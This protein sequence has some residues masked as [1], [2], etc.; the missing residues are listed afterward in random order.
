MKY[1]LGFIGAGNMAEALARGALR[2]GVVEAPQMLAA[3]PSPE[4]REVFD[5]LG[6]A[7]AADPAAVVAGCDHV[8]L[9]VKPQVFAA[10]SPVLAALDRKQQ[11]VIS[12]MAGVRSS[13]IEAAAG[14]PLRILRVMPN[15]P[16]LVGRGMSGMAECSSAEGSRGD[17]KLCVDLLRSC[18]EVAKVTE[19]DMDAVTAVSGSGPAYVFLLAE[20]MMDAAAEMGLLGAHELFVQQTICGAAEMLMQSEESA[21]ELRRKVTSPGGTTQAAIESFD[22]AGFRTMVRDAMR[23][24]CRRSAELGA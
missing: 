4:R 23:A 7:T 20:A 16:M 17:T 1:R 15:T 6:I 19:D 14:G 11:T 5:K 22:A 2:G 9:A 24:A 3:D 12:I 10:V 13:T 21:A 8:L 18:G